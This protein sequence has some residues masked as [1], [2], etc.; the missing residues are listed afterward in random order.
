M[1][2]ELLHRQALEITREALGEAHLNYA[3]GLG[4][5]G[6]LLGET[7]RVAEGRGMLEQAL[8]IFRAAL[9]AD[10]PH[11]AITQGHL[12]ALPDG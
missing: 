8:A 10:H 4:N 3:L 7:D 9:P 1:E 6:R 11:I 2:A 12:D 5:L